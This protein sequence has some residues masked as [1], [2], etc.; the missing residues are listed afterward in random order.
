MDVAVTSSVRCLVGWKR[1]MQKYCV[2]HVNLAL[3]CAVWV[4]RLELDQNLEENEYVEN[5]ILAATR[6][7]QPGELIQ[8]VGKSIY[9]FGNS[10][11]QFTMIM[12]GVVFGLAA[13]SLFLSRFPPLTEV[14]SVI[15]LLLILLL[16]PISAFLVLAPLMDLTIKVK[17]VPI[18]EVVIIT[19]QRILLVRSRNFFLTEVGKK[20]EIAKYAAEKGSLQLTLHNGT[21]FELKVIDGLVLPR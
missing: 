20:T 14:F 16:F 2:S 3:R 7:L 13:A 10:S 4:R 1:R 12:F 21:R 19:N 15:F 17:Q 8:T 9:S 6:N 18:E 5:A 11:T